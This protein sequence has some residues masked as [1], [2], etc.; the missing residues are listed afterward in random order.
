MSSHV[1][2]FGSVPVRAKTFTLTVAEAVTTDVA[3]AAV[4]ADMPSG[5]GADELELDPLVAAAHIPTN[6]S[7]EV[8]VASLGGR[9]T[10]QRRVLISLA[11]PA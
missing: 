3:L 8:V 10:G 4:S 1:V 5:V 11:T 2:D 7:V 9:V 6:G